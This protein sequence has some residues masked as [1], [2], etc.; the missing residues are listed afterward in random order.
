MRIL[1]LIIL[2]LSVIPSPG[3][4]DP[5]YTHPQKDE[6]KKAVK[7]MMNRSNWTIIFI[8]DSNSE[9]SI[10]LTFE[11]KKIHLTLHAATLTQ[12]EKRLAKTYFSK[13]NIKLKKFK[14]LNPKTGKPFNIFTWRAAYSIAEIDRVVNLAIGALFE[15][16]SVTPS[17]PLKI[18]K[19][20]EHTGR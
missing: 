8:T 18:N 14:Y 5:V 4:E 17:I 12:E 10:K 7:E 19:A 3:A 1:G 15:V 16:F 11:S 6:V 9:H 13:H 2:L 20:W